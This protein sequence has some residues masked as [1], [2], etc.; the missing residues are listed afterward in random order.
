MG[1][2]WVLL[3]DYLR[4][5]GGTNFLEFR[6]DEFSLDLDRGELRHGG[7]AVATEPL[8]FAL[9]THLVEN[10]GILI[11]KDELVER[12]WDGRFISDAAIST[13]IKSA[14]RALGDDGTAQRYIRTVHGRGFRFVGAVTLHTP[15]GAAAPPSEPETDRKGSA[16]TLAVL[17]FGLIGD[18]NGRQAIADGLSSE[19]IA[20]LARLRW[21]KVIARGSSFRFRGPEFDIPEIRTALG[22]TYILTGEVELTGQR[23]AVSFELIDSWTEQVIW[24]DRVAGPLDEV[25]RLRED[26]VILVTSALEVHIPQNEARL[27]RMQSPDSLDAWAFYHTGLQHVYRSNKADN[28]LATNYFRRAVELDPTFARAYGALSFANFQ[29]AFLRYEGDRDRTISDAKRNAERGLELDPLDPF[30]NFNFGRAHWLEG[31]PQ[32]SLG[33]L[34]QATILSPSFAQGLYARGWAEVME[35]EGRASLEHVTR[36]TELSP[37]DPMLYAMLSCKGIAYMNIGDFEQASDWAAR[38]ARKPGAHFL[39]KAVAAAANELGGQAEKA[40]YWRDQ[41]FAARP[42]ASVQMFFTA[43]PFRDE[44]FRQKLQAALV[45]LGYPET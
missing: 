22:A 36:A 33:W 6:F 5:F 16:P 13:V 42:D 4:N 14:R 8:A 30:V 9:L 15:A 25:H 1:L 7:E 29:S 40:A 27:A 28:A 37:L 44:A 39:I 32:S 17:P 45:R 20:T 23:A 10:A 12:V 38:G 3:G 21:L 19:L 2:L 11:S 43:F 24:A 18:G 41:S 35:G 26:I 34:E 31:D